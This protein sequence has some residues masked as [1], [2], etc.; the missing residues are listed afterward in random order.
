MYRFIF[1]M[2]EAKEISFE[3]ATKLLE[4]YEQTRNKR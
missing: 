3:A 1:K 2:Y 4:K